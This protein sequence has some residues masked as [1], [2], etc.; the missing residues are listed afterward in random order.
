MR[1]CYLSEDIV[2][3]RLMVRALFVV[4]MLCSVLSLT[5]A[6]DERFVGEW[7]GTAGDPRVDEQWR[8]THVGDKWAVFGYY[9]WNAKGVAEDGKRTAGE[10]AGEFKGQ[11]VRLVEGTLKFTQKFNPKPFSSWAD[12][13]DIDARVAGDTITFTNKY[14]KTGVELVRAKH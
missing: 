11:N 9:F 13:T 10:L 12:N 8:I 5:Y 6:Q 1:R 7:D 3:E 14:V 4:T 2:M